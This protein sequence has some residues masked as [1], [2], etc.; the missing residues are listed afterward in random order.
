M[1]R[2]PDKEYIPDQEKTRH[3]KKKSKHKKFAVEMRLKPEE[4]ERRKEKI[5]KQRIEEP[6]FNRDDC[7]IRWYADWTVTGRYEKQRDVDQALEN[8]RKKDGRWHEQF[9][10]RQ[11]PIDKKGTG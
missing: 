5:R 3:R 7:M 10:Y 9:E 6:W 4:L 8:Y 2:K 1:K 11:R